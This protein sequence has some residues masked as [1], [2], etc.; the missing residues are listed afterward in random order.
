MAGS[1]HG[2]RKSVEELEALATA[3]GRP[4]RQRTTTYGVVPDERRAAALAA[5]VLLPVVD[6]HHR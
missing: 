4:A 3:A 5:P 6:S 2:S 1:Q